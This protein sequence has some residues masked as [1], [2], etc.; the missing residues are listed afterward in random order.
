[1]N[2]E[3]PSVTSVKIA[4][5]GLVVTFDGNPKPEFYSW[6]W[7]RDHSQDPSRHDAATKQRKVDTFNLD[8]LVHGVEAA[9]NGQSV[10]ISWSDESEPG[11]YSIHLLAEVAGLLGSSSLP[12]FWSS[13]PSTQ[14]LLRIPFNEVVTT[15]HGLSIWLN[16]V[17]TLGYGLVRN[18]PTTHDGAESLARRVG[19]PRQTIFGD[20]WKLSSEMTDHSDT[21][22][23]QTFLEPHTDGTYSH[24]APGLQL[25]CCIEREGDGGESIL[26]DGFAIAEKLKIQD[27]SAFE[28]L[29]R[30]I[31][32]AHYIEPGIHLA[33]ERPVIRLDH[34]GNVEQVSF[35]NYDRAPFRLPPLD[36]KEFYRAYAKFHEL[37]NDRETWL[38]VRLN[39]GDALLFD[40]W[41]I[42]HGR[43]AYIGHRVFIGCYH[44]CEDFESRRRVLQLAASAIGATIAIP[45]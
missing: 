36:E 2:I 40:N 21:A 15:D 7:L 37:L 28:V 12:Q 38:I 22:Y 11:E 19:Y 20:L 31:V 8:P 42:L 10:R 18:M 35:N 23:S 6:L 5:D 16:D 24:D 13:S 17:A 30:V 1:M 32:R 4:A 41:R 45:A 44:N 26:V 14:D 25:F 43:M 33:A 39:P 34:S 29:T 27:P 9:L 3:C